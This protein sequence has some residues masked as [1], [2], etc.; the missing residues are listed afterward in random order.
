M[1]I[2]RAAVCLS[3]SRLEFGDAYWSNR[4]TEDSSQSVPGCLEEKKCVARLP[5]GSK[6]R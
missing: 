2:L 6:D 1:V 3:L 5:Q 4:V